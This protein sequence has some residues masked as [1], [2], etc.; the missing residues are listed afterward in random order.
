MCQ[1]MSL[2]AFPSVATLASLLMPVWLYALDVSFCFA[3]MQT[4]L[5][6]RAIRM[7]R[8]VLI[9]DVS[10][11]LQHGQNT[12]MDRAVRVAQ[13]RDQLTAIVCDRIQP[14]C[15]AGHL[16]QFFSGQQWILF[17]QDFTLLIGGYW[18]HG[19]DVNWLRFWRLLT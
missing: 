8:Q 12:R 4:R 11:H 9:G 10:V 15:T 3:T 1:G 17:E 18:F 7:F 16:V 13:V 14:D 2:L 19:I 6:E 5:V